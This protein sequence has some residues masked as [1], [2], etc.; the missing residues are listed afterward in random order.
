V[1]CPYTKENYI[2]IDIVN[3][4]SI[5]ESNIIEKNFG[6]SQIK[7]LQVTIDGYKYISEFDV[8]KMTQPDLV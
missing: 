6:K 3:Q 8:T 1:I 7:N 4:L 5:L 2:Y